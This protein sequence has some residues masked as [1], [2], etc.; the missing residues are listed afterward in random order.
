M[1]QGY[2]S[3]ARLFIILIISVLLLDCTSDDQT[4]QN[5]N[6]QVSSSSTSEMRSSNKKRKRKKK[7][8]RRRDSNND[9]DNEDGDN[10]DDDNGDDDNGD[11]DNGDGD[12]GDDDNG[13]DDNDDDDNGNGD[14]PPDGS[15]NISPGSNLERY[16]PQT[17]NNRSSILNTNPYDHLRDVYIGSIA[18]DENGLA[19]YRSTGFG[20]RQNNCRGEK[21]PQ[22]P[23]GEPPASNYCRGNLTWLNDRDNCNRTPGWLR[24]IETDRWEDVEIDRDGNVIWHEGVFLGIWENGIW[25][26]GVFAGGTWKNGTWENGVF[27]G[28][29]KNGTWENGVFCYSAVS[30]QGTRGPTSTRNHSS[31]NFNTDPFGS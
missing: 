12:N 13:D 1:N 22:F 11:D 28:C 17:E 6:E 16:F 31:C 27:D 20:S 18:R 24:T 10:G 5:T 25:K 30:E 14:N 4:P 26:D 29:W 19:I 23:C 2:I 3:L 9:D 21:Y 7:K 15:C 8:R